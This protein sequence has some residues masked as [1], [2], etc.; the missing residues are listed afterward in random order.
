MNT[1]LAVDIGASS[2]RLVA[3]TLESGRLTLREIHRFPNGAKR[4]NGHLCW[5]VDTLFDEIVKGLRVCGD[6]GVQP[7]SLGVD[8]WG[9]DYALLDAQGKRVGD[10]IAYRDERTAGIPDT[11]DDAAL[12]ART[13]IQRQPFNTVYQLLADDRLGSAERMLLMPEYLHNL[14]TG[15]AVS[16]YTNATTTA[17]VNAKTRDWD[18]E[19]IAQ[20]R[21]PRRLFGALKQP[22]ETVG[23]LKQ[24]IAAR[25][26]FQTNVV[27]PPT[28]DTAAAVLGAPIEENDIFL[29]SGTWSL[30]GAE[31]NRPVLTKEARLAGMTNEGGVGGTYRFLKNITGMWMIERLRDEMP[32]KPSYDDIAALSRENE[33]FVGRVDVNA[34]EFLA[35]PSMKT[36]IED[37]LKA[38]GQPLPRSA[39]ELFACVQHSLAESYGRTV[40]DIEG[41]CGKTFSRIIVV[42]GGSRNGLLNEWT[43]RACE[44]AVF[45]GPTEG[46]A[47]GNLLSQ[48]LASGEISSVLEARDI[49]ANSFERRQYR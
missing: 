19:L 2:G 43:A 25:C 3:G 7:V 11:L 16:E 20:L 34:P 29:S 31:M 9:V 32:Q 17:L 47:L 5:D 12:Y 27:L 30:I 49:V 35:P 33:G 1:Y 24:E 40:R 37:H 38:H 18:D 8:T 23:A 41:L 4:K 22:G 44:K 14:L 21:L 42:G 13:G 45:A 26:G 46:T 15:V 10:A 6:M 48:M 36:A 39:G 28:H